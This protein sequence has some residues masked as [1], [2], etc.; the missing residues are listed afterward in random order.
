[1]SSL[2]CFSFRMTNSAEEEFS[3]GLLSIV[4]PAIENVDT[5]VQTL[6]TTQAKLKDCIEN[7]SGDLTNISDMQKD[8]PN[9]EHYVKKLMS[10]KR[11]VTTVNNVLTNVQDRVQVLQT[12]VT[13]EQAR[14]R[15]L[16]SAS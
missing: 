5:Q 1:M 13:K 7:L 10:I 9:L 2:I 15:T 11:R 4:K 3:E 8:L 6:R 14:K 16:L 12:R